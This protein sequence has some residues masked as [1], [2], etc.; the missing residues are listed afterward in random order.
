MSNK[1]KTKAVVVIGLLFLLLCVFGFAVMIILNHYRA[2]YLLVA[3]FATIALT[4]AVILP[5][6]QKRISFQSTLLLIIAI[7][8]IASGTFEYADDNFIRPLPVLQQ[9]EF[10]K[11]M[12]PN[13]VSD[14]LADT[15]IGV[16]W[17]LLG[18]TL[19]KLKPSADKTQKK[20]LL[21][22]MIGAGILF[23]ILGISSVFSGLRPL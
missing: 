16:T 4:I 1:E 6:R 11:S 10:S 2:S 9:I 21:M 3:S 15:G 5:F 7:L 20:P 14:G 12:R 17:I 22:F 19:P 23:L 8:F 18:I 13:Q